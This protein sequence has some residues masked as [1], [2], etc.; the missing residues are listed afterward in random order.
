MHINTLEQN[1]LL[2]QC[3]KLMDDHQS[4]QMNALAPL[5]LQL[6]KCIFSLR[7]SVSEDHA[8]FDSAKAR[9]GVWRMPSYM[10]VTWLGFYGLQ[11]LL[12]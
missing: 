10:E 2:Y 9:E 7:M 5:K 11:G 3:L 6:P 8:T 12:K 1:S 4:F